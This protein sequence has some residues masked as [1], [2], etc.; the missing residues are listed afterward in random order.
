MTKT[1]L[2]LLKKISEESGQWEWSVGVV[3]GSG[4]QEWSVGVISG[5]R[6]WELSVGVVSG[7]CQWEW[8]VGVVGESGQWEWSVGVVGVQ[9]N[10]STPKEPQ[11]TIYCKPHGEVWLAYLEVYG[12]S[13][14]DGVKEVV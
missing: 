8:S 4:Q 10:C 11:R 9:T 2:D 6:Q 5:S 13:W 7:S 1:S 14:S 3:S 12:L